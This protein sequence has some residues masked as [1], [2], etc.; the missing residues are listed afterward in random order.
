M[1][2]LTFWLSGCDHDDIQRELPTE[3]GGNVEQRNWRAVDWNVLSKD[4]GGLIW[5]LGTKICFLFAIC[6]TSW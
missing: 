5:H 3:Q 1:N 6:F 2:L 4:H